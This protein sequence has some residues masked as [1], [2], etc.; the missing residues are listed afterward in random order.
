MV[1]ASYTISG[2][3]LVEENAFNN[4]V[5]NFWSGSKASALA[6]VALLK[7]RFLLATVAR[8]ALAW[9]KS[10]VSATCFNVAFV[11]L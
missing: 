10:V 8:S 9:V 7:R 2:E 11:G 1:L 3:A 4:R 6:L 5:D